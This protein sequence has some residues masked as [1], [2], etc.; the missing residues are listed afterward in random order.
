MPRLDELP[1]RTPATVTGVAWDTLTDS[2]S[3]RLRNLGLDDGVQIE[4]LH[5]APFGRDPLA[6][7][8]G[9]MMVAIR[10]DHAR[11]VSVEVIALETAAE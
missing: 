3:R 8:I 4:L 1:F 10:R 2:E 9:R 5:A 7:K 6:V 11:A